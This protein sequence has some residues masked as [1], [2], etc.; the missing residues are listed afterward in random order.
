MPFW[1]YAK[2]DLKKAFLKLLFP[3]IQVKQVLQLQ[4]VLSNSCFLN[5]SAID[6]KNH[7]TLSK[8]KMQENQKIDSGNWTRWSNLL[9]WKSESVRNRQVTSE[10]I[11]YTIHFCWSRLK[12][13]NQQGEL[14]FPGL[15]S[16]NKISIQS[17]SKCRS[18]IFKLY[19]SK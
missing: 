7:K 6:Q 4:M 2:T 10:L 13:R 16:T 11:F 17:T 5:P 3:N 9:K 18:I 8:L 1:K 12:D 14:K 15:L 19:S